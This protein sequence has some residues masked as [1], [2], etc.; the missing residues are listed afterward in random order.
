MESDVEDTPL[1]PAVPYPNRS[2]SINAR[3]AFS[4]TISRPVPSSLSFVPR[5]RY[6]EPAPRSAPLKTSYS[7]PWENPLKAAEHIEKLND[8]IQGLRHHLTLKNFDLETAEAELARVSEAYSILAKEKAELVDKL[9]KV[10]RRNEE[11]EQRVQTDDRY[12]AVHY[13][14]APR[15][16]LTPEF[17]DLKQLLAARPDRFEAREQK[18]QLWEDRLRAS[19]VSLAQRDFQSEPERPSSAVS[20]SIGEEPRVV[21][22]PDAAAIDSVLVSAPPL[23]PF[24]LTKLDPHFRQPDFDFAEWSRTCGLEL[25]GDILC[26]RE[27]DWSQRLEVNS[28]KLE[29]LG[30][31]NA[32]D[33]AYILRVLCSIAEG[34]VGSPF[35]DLL[36]RLTRSGSFSS[37]ILPRRFH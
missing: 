17:P 9:L 7:S 25:P 24:D 16:R 28:E 8:V 22:L 27:L 15:A 10:L 1:P 19:E 21:K 29:K 31:K 14:P 37:S 5:S 36:V 23:P 12:L 35:S 11:L 34:E 33:R 3:P 32:Q 26:L 20:G 4:P 2:N 6:V 18:V 13:Q 30:V